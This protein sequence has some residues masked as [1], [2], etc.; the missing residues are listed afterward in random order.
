MG[1]YS[2]EAARFFEYKSHGVGA[3]KDPKRR[4]LSDVQA[5]QYGSDEVLAGWKP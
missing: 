1:G 3:V 4:I 2:A 5:A